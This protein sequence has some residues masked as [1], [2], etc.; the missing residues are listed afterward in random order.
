MYTSYLE[1]QPGYGVFLN[2][3]KA[4][5]E[6]YNALKDF[7]ILTIGSDCCRY[8]NKTDVERAA[9]RGESL[10]LEVRYDKDGTKVTML[11]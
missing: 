9:G 7:L 4:V 3:Q 8:I 2:S 1:V 11:P 6:H 5:R 10:R